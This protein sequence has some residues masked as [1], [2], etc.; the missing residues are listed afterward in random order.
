[1]LLILDIVYVIDVLKYDFKTI[2]SD[3]KKIYQEKKFIIIVFN[4]IDLIDNKILLPYI[5]S[6]NELKYIDSFFNISAKY[7]RGLNRL[8]KYLKS[9]SFNKKWIF[10]K[11]EVSN[12]NDIF[13]SNECTRNAILKYLHQEIPYNLIVRNIFIKILKNK[14]IK[15]KQSI[16]LKNLRYKSIILGK[17]GNTIKKIRE[18]SQK[19]IAHIMKVKVHLYLQI[20]RLHD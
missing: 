7:S 19:E 11:D 3:L 18:S 9:K 1:M 6:L 17:N 13:I 2:C 20:N 15:I 12:K 8:S 14:H 10:N 4:K 5:K 16:D